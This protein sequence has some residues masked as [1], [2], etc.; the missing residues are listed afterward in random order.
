MHIPNRFYRA[1]VNQLILSAEGEQMKT[2]NL[3]DGVSQS[4]LY[5]ITSGE[6]KRAIGRQD[7][8]KD[9]VDPA[10]RIKKIEK[11]SNTLKAELNNSMKKK[12][13]T[14]AVDKKVNK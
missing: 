2:L 14:L 6:V 1:S 9:I 13:S 3:L 10:E 5:F 4:G 11:L 7:P 12:A 8:F